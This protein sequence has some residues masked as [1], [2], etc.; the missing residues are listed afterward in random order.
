MLRPLLIAALLLTACGDDPAPTPYVT[1]SIEDSGGIVAQLLMSAPLS[2]IVLT[3]G[4]GNTNDLEPRR[5]FPMTVTLTSKVQGE[6]LVTVDVFATDGT[7]D[8]LALRGHAFVDI[9]AQNGQVVPLALTILCFGDTG[10]CPPMGA[11]N[12]P[13]T[14]DA[15]CDDGVYCNGSQSCQGG[16]CRFNGPVCPTPSDGCLLSLCYEE[17]DNCVT[18]PNTT[19]P[20]CEIVA[21][22]CVS[23]L[24]CQDGSV[25]NGEEVCE[26]G[27]CVDGTPFVAQPYPCMTDVCSEALGTSGAEL[28]PDG[29]ACGEGVCEAGEC[30][31]QLPTRDCD[32]VI[33]LN[34]LADG[35][36]L[37]GNGMEV[38][39]DE[40]VFPSID[41]PGTPTWTAVHTATGNTLV[42][43]ASIISNTTFSFYV[44]YPMR[45]GSMRIRTAAGARCALTF[46]PDTSQRATFV[47]ST[48]PATLDFERGTLFFNEDQRFRMT[49]TCEANATPQ[50]LRLDHI[51]LVER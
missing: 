7:Q 26:G 35:Q 2:R 22:E 15:D 21:P 4:S 47:R 45:L 29:L 40:L 32:R 20:D 17:A 41:A 38:S 25:C 19:R 39:I 42:P 12:G 10:S 49:V 34:S 31:T 27:Q 36:L 51:C 16:H 33:D 48:D 9:A 46:T 43:R 18:V 8:L 6:Q 14:S 30:Y 5:T 50:T 37:G 3:D 1:L 23:S 11:S 24:Q 13:C 28:L 44:K